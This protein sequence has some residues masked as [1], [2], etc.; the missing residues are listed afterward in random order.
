MF[1]F[2][3]TSTF[4]AIKHH[5]LTLEDAIDQIVNYYEETIKCMPGNVYIFDKDLS[6]I[7]CNQNVLDM[8]GYQSI[9]EFKTKTQSQVVYTR[10]LTRYPLDNED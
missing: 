10:A 3:N 7:T 1:Y 6:P 8:L 5:S 2:P 4:L 9:N